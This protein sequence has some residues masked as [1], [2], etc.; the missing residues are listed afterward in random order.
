ML[1]ILSEYRKV[2]Q[3]ALLLFVF[4]DEGKE[5]T[6]VKNNNRKH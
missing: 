5:S 2:A 4:T 3:Q 1:S 6:R